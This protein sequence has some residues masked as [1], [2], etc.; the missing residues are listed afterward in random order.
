[1]AVKAPVNIR[2]DDNIFDIDVHPSSNIVITGMING[3]VQCH[4]YGV[5]SNSHLWTESV[6]KKSCRGVRFTQDGS[7]IYAISRDRSIRL[8]DTETGKEIKMR[9]KT[10]EAPLNSLL[11]IDH[12]MMATGDD[13]GVI[14]HKS[15]L[16]VGGDGY[17]SVWDIRK[18]NVVA[19]SD[20]MEDEL[21]SIELI[22]NEKKAIVGTQDGILT[23]WSWGDWG[24]YNDRI[25]G[26]PKSI[27][28]LCKLDE[29]TVCTGS[30]DGIIR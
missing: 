27:D 2:F 20:Q 29:D 3:Q 22:K 7:N 16:A 9:E 1:M 28:A 17:L 19:M 30:S 24:D 4:Q 13:Q 21:L 6:F 15:L 10:H 18:P 12:H 8:L 26:H 5:E 11:T 23:L 25:V 14:K